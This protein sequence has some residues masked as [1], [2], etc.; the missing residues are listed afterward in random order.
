[1]T[2]PSALQRPSVGSPDSRPVRPRDA[3]S[4]ILLRGGPGG[5]KGEIEVLMGRRLGRASFMPDHYVFPGGRIDAADSRARPASDLDLSALGH[6]KVAGRAVR[7][8]ALAMAAVRETFEETGLLLGA[9]GDVGPVEEETWREIRATGL[10]PALARLSYVGRA[11]TPTDSP[12][13]FHARFFMA[14]ANHVTGTLGGSGELVDLHWTP[15]SEALKLPLPDITEFLLGT[16]VP[17]QL[18]ATG[19]ARNLKAYFTYRNGGPHIR[20]DPI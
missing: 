3:A 16:E 1:M 5:N 4:L 18:A 10:A 13:R 12:I 14:D 11:I 9:P 20:L 7:A 15:L 19:E 2:G 6:M 17:R 8:R